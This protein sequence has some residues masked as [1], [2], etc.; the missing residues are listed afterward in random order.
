MTCR[1]RLFKSPDERMSKP[2]AF[3]KPLQQN[4]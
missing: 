1:P 3:P 4:I 2:I